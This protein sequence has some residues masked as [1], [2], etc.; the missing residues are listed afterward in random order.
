MMMMMLTMMVIM[1]VMV[2][3]M[4]SLIV[5]MILMMKRIIF[6][7]ILTCYDDYIM[8]INNFRKGASSVDLAT[9][10]EDGK[11]NAKRTNHLNPS[12]SQEESSKNPVFTHIT[13]CTGIRQAFTTLLR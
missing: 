1:M 4:M 9:M 13:L 7:L 2:M 5:M 3:I 12:L 10:L 11:L 6:L 8:N